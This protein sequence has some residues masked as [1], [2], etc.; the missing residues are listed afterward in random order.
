VRRQQLVTIFIA[1]IALARA[2]YCDAD[3]LLLDDPLSAGKHRFNLGLITLPARRPH[4]LTLPLIEY[5]VDS[6]VGRLLFYGAIQDLGL[7]RGKCV[8][9]VTHQHQFIGDARCVVMSC[10]S[11]ASVGSY[12]QCIED[13]GGKLRLVVQN[14]ESDIEEIA[15]DP[16]QP[17]YRTSNTEPPLSLD[18]AKEPIDDS[19]RSI[20]K[21]EHKE[22]SN[23]GIVKRETFL[24]YLKGKAYSDICVWLQPKLK[25]SILVNSKFVLLQFCCHHSYAWGALYGAFHASFIRHNA[26]LCTRNYRRCWKVV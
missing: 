1:G 22:M 15:Q 7:K 11:I 23:S 6:K 26:K 9:L 18:A 5:L 14:K 13:S 24:N 8:V 10:G 20:N 4:F 21:D 2:F 12:K 3:I 17:Q 16:D 25:M 19:N